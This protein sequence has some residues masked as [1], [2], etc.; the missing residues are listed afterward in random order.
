MERFFYIEHLGCAKNRV[1]ADSMAGA[2][3]S[4]GWRPTDEAADASLIVV[5]SCGFIGPAKRESIEA[6]LSL[7]RRC[8][9]A[10]IILAGCLAQRYLDDL[11][12]SLVEIDGF[13]G[14]RDP[15]RIVEMI[16][17][18][19]SIGRRIFAPAPDTASTS[20]SADEH[21][22]A[23][24]D[25][26][27]ATGYVKIAEGCDNRCTF[28]AIPL[29]RGRLRSRSEDDVVDDVRRLLDRGVFEINVI[30]QD[31]ASYGGD[32]PAAG[33]TKVPLLRLVE[34]ILKLPGEFWL[35]LLYIH[36][37][38]FPRELP[39]LV[40]SDD[41]LLPYFDLPFQHASERLLRAMG[42][43]G[44]ASTY[45]DLIADIREALPDSVIRSTFLVGFPRENRSDAEALLDF[46]RKAQIDWLGIFEYSPEEG[47]AA[48][49]RPSTRRSKSAR[50]LRRV[51]E[52]RQTPISESRMERFVGHHLDVLI[53]EPLGDMAIG[54]GFLHAPEVDGN[55]V[56]HGVGLA[57][58]T[59][60]RCHVIKRNGI[61]LEAV[62]G[63]DDE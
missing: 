22:S 62:V 10:R 33:G 45:I 11:A 29:I 37:D 23:A 6:A 42:R 17:E 27:G 55:V 21:V 47:T 52:E 1:D 16:E 19:G 41:R 46:Q 53:E 56:V 3:E 34:R 2:L 8:P 15:R 51:L 28:C 36:P 26:G 38:H 43:R 5:N 61:D 58:G 13:F 50:R 40:G 49:V 24:A 59:V 31:I 4:S 44:N 12:R 60:R 9:H 54:R 57:S 32:Q 7:R 48:Y 39:A 14:N 35:R 18:S 30:G 63:R 25:V 20:T